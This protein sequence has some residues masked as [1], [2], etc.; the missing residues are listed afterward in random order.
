MYLE[1][2]AGVDHA[3]DPLPD[4]DAKDAE[5]SLDQWEAWRDEAAA[6]GLAFGEFLRQK[7]QMRARHVA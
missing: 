6:T 4:Q 3:T 1:L 5:K 7:L 2:P